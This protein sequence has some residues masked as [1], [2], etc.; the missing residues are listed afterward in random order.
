MAK[1]KQEKNKE[2]TAQ[3]KAQKILIARENDF[4]KKIKAEIRIK[5]LRSAVLALDYYKNHSNV[6]YNENALGITRQQIVRIYENMIAEYKGDLQVKK[7]VQTAKK[8]KV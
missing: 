8:Q 5:G 2:L 3:E 7:Q 1:L 6:A 4:R